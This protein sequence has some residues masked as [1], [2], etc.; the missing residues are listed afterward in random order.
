MAYDFG[1][2]SEPVS[3]AKPKY[4]FGD[5]AHP[6]ET[7]PA[8]KQKTAKDIF[9]RPD[10]LTELAG[11][12]VEPALKMATG[13]LARPASQVMQMSA[14]AFGDPE[15][16]EHLKGFQEHMQD[17]LTYHPKTQLGASEGNLLNAIPSAI[18]DRKS[19]V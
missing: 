4:D 6:E 2:L 16:V 17:L 1:G 15:D 12:V 13:F 8:Q 11:G 5:L 18:G 3:T 14:A 10:Y 9:D 19:V 7:S